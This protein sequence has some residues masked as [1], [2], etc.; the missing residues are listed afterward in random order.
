M[1]EGDEAFMR[2]AMGA[3]RQQVEQALAHPVGGGPQ[4]RRRV[5]LAERGEVKAPVFAGDDPHAAISA[6]S[7]TPGSATAAASGDRPASISR[8]AV[9]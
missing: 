5:A 8:F 3:V 2:V 4:M 6:L 7:S 9:M 1:T